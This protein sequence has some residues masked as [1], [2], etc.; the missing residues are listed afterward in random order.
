MSDF[1]TS[2]ARFI[3]Q[4]GLLR[5]GQRVLVGVSGG[6]DSMVCLAL[7]HRLG[8]DV[9]AF[10]VNYGLREGADA[11]EA[12]V[13]RW[14]ERCSPP[15]PLHTERLDA[16]ERADA[17]GASL[18]AV[19]RRL[20]YDALAGYARQHNI[21]AVAVGHH[22]DD[23]AETVLLNLLRGSGPE[24]LAGMPPARTL[25][26]SDVRLVR[27][28][29]ETSR[30]TIQAYA[31]QQDIPWRTDPSNDDPAYDRGVL[32][33]EILPRLNDRFDGAS[34][35]L[36]RT[37]GLL[38]EYVDDLLRPALESALA[39]HYEHCHAGGRLRIGPLRT[40]PS[41]WRRRV[42]LAA[43]ERALPE[44]SRTAAVAEELEGLLEG[45]VGR[46]IE[47]TSGTVWRERRCLRFVP[48]GSRA[49]DDAPVPVPW[50]ADVPL[51]QG[52]VRLDPLDTV[53]DSLDTGTPYAAYVDLDR[54]ADPL[55][56]RPWREGDRIQPL[57]MQGTKTVSDLLTD[58]KVPPHCRPHICVL[59]TPDHLAWV[60]GHRLD[61]RVRVR[62]ST[63]RAA[64][65]RWH[66]H[67]NTPHD[68]ISPSVRDR[69][70]LSSSSF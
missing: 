13:R 7:L 31:E 62:P 14:C 22:Q 59:T 17:T 15:V 68:C 37:A 40:A 38:R 66:P 24:G 44:A 45:Q 55:A 69:L 52:T 19:A 18:Q 57:G 29:L 26:Q 27:P 43:L 5:D 51:P 42:L 41:V 28:L 6:V 3:A 9:T 33:T 12:L 65:L 1:P 32:R 64:R 23:Q 60:I 16:R 46:R 34:T 11:D 8:Y 67:E 36:A 70:P 10:H 2:V 49:E 53:P 50:G 48:V 21:D 56:V 63:E 39:Q 25:A 54:L 61:H 4:H 30:R 58:A 35:T 47:V 20:R